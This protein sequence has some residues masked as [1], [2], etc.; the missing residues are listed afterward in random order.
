MIA[1]EVGKE[2]MA[3]PLHVA[4]NWKSE[5]VERLAAQK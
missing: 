4:I 5:L 3:S 1:V 2:T